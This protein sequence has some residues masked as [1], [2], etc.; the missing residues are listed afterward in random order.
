MPTANIYASRSKSWV[1][2]GVA[3]PTLYSGTGLV[4]GD[5][6]VKIDYINGRVF[7][8]SGYTGT[9]SGVYRVNEFNVYPT[10]ETEEDL[11]IERKWSSNP[12]YGLGT[13]YR[14]AYIP[15][16]DPV[17]PA[18]FV[19]ISTTVNAPFAFGGEDESKKYV[20]CVIMSPDEYLLDGAISLFVDQKHKVIP[21]LTP[22][23]TPFNEIGGLK[24][25]F[26]Y[27]GLR[28]TNVQAL[29]INNV[30][31]SKLSENLRTK[32]AQLFYVG[33]LDIDLSAYRYT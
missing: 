1:Y 16:Y 6:N 9:L 8:P 29:D 4:S 5:P 12:R 32:I 17:L 10:N 18:I 21:L 31:G 27:S 7:M 11:V 13:G 28:A 22:D 3:A 23:Q 14:G 33:F 25:G 26:S 24:S 19:T 20:K 15:P 30:Q 2:D